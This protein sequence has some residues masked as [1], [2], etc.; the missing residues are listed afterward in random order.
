MQV[1]GWPRRGHEPDAKGLGECVTGEILA[2]ISFGRHRFEAQHRALAHR[3]GS[4][5]PAEC[6]LKTDNLGS[7]R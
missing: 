5:I 3:P 7:A 2:G 4:W 1:T 6:L